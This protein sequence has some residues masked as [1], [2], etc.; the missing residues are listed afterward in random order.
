M[1]KTKPFH[2]FKNSGQVVS[3][4]LLGNVLEYFD[5]TLFAHFGLIIT[6]LFFP[7]ADPTATC[8]CSM[9]LLAIGFIA[10]PLG[11]FIFG[12]IGDRYGR[13]KGLSLSMLGI[14]VPTLG[15][16]MLP[17]YAHIGVAA[18]V[19]IILL[20][21]GQG[22]ALGGEY[23]TAAVFIIEHT[24]PERHGL[25]SGIICASGSIGS[26]AAL[27]CVEVINK[28][29][30]AVWA[31]RI[32]FLFAS[33]TGISTYY[34]R[35]RLYETPQFLAFQQKLNQQSVLENTPWFTIGC[36]FAIGAVT[37]LFVWIP[38]SYTPYYLTKVIGWKLSQALPYTTL[39]LVS[40]MTFLI[41]T[42]FIADKIG[43]L[44]CMLFGLCLMIALTYPAFL[45]LESQHIACFQVLTTSFAGI[46]GAT[47]HP[48]MINSCQ[49]HQR[50]RHI[51]FY[52][53]AG[54]SLCGGTA[55]FVCAYLFNLTH[56]H[57]WV[58]AYIIVIATSALLVI[59]QLKFIKVH[60]NLHQPYY[61]I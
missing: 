28:G 39:G 20:R 46:F 47:I 54:L 45:L 3:L 8:L 51:G 24:T 43:F 48:V 14:I 9:G 53:T 60:D 52:F 59:R 56:T 19:L 27:A 4:A 23:G 32:P 10:R 1:Q 57:K 40:F 29:A 22:V 12:T 44:K 15:I 33:V 26:L 36:I 13:S 2:I 6:P 61:G 41:I 18:S 49:L 5:F 30:F 25:M 17:T 37:S 16:A 42:G 21:L 50:C 34:L 31:W 7:T 38:I 58:S 11:G 35:R 55:P